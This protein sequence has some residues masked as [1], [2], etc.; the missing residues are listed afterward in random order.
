M[1]FRYCWESGA[2]VGFSFC[3]RYSG[4][5]FSISVRRW[6]DFSRSQSQALDV[7]PGAGMRKLQ[8]VAEQGEADFRRCPRTP[9]RC[10]LRSNGSSICRH[11]GA[12]GARRILQSSGRGG[13]SYRG[14]RR[15][16]RQ[17]GQTR[18][19]AQWSETWL[20]KPAKG[21]GASSARANVGISPAL[22]V[23][24]FIF[25]IIPRV[26]SFILQPAVG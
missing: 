22:T 9:E 2:N 5:R 1:V 4:A 15:S 6:A 21:P 3:E 14:L 23:G 25:S 13:V 18:G 24:G 16:G 10:A 11:A 17:E 20:G 8:Q 7:V 26:R 19:M 12:D